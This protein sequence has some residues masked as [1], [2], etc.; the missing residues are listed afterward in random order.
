MLFNTTGTIG[1]ILQYATTEVTGSIFLTLLGI[2]IGLMVLCMLLR[3]PME[4]TAI[5]VL[6]LLLGC[7][8]YYSEFTAILGVFLIYLGVIVGKNFFFR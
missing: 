8:S 6:P 2:V 4:F 3:L 5:L 7:A 1:V